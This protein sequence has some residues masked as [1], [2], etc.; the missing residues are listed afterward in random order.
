M[1][2]LE[3][4]DQIEE[5]MTEGNEGRVYRRLFPESDLDMFAS[6][7]AGGIPVQRVRAVELLVASQV[8]EE[9]ELPRETRQVVC[10]LDPREDE[11][12]AIVFAL[13]EEGSQELFAAMAADIAETAVKCEDEVAAAH[14][15]CGRFSKWRRM[16]E[17]SG[18]GLSVRRQMG[19]ASELLTLLEQLVPVVGVEPAVLAWLGPQGNPRDFEIQAFGIE[20][21]ASGA[22]EPQVVTVSNERQL[23]DSGLSGLVLIHRSFE[24]VRGGEQTLPQ[25]VAATRQ[26]VDGTSVEGTLEEAL[27]DSGYVDAHAQIYEAKS[28]ENRQ[29]RIF[30][31]EDG[32]PRIT[33]DDLLDGVGSVSYQ[34][35]IDACHEFRLPNEKWT[36]YLEEELG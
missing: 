21:K 36:E 17:G 33:E 16:F 23:D 26:R 34:L 1:N 27:L 19:L 24:V 10:D 4:W 2:L 15:W 35:A 20:A 11:M 18:R 6:V 14:T 7:I 30:R 28:F 25:I 3:L 32:F 9:L 5:S 8:A 31:V 12:T 29:T 22:H 13:N